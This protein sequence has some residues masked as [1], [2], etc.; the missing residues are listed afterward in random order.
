MK[1][2]ILTTLVLLTSVCAHKAIA[3]TSEAQLSVLDKKAMFMTCINRG[4][5]EV[6][7]PAASFDCKKACKPNDPRPSAQEC[8]DA[9]QAATGQVYVP[10]PQNNNPAPVS[11]SIR[12]TGN[13]PPQ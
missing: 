6:I 4:P 8:L 13:Y 11:N 12:G 2:Y 5:V 3:Q 1:K 10:I 7:N 9:Y